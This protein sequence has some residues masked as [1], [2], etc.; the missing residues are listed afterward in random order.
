MILGLDVGT[1][2]TKAV[3]LEN[4]N[5]KWRHKIATEADPDRAVN[6]ILK[7]LTAETGLDVNDLDET[8]ITGWGQDKVSTPHGF[9]PI[10]KCLARG[11]LWSDPS[12]RS[13]LCIGAQQSVVLSLNE[14]GR[15]LGFWMN[16][17]C[18]S[19]AGMFLE[20]ICE[21]LRCRV[22]E[23]SDI[24]AT[25]DQ[26]LK[27]SSQCAVFAES[28][29]VSLVNDGE[30]VANIMK[31]ILTALSQNI[32]TLCK[33]ITHK[34]TFMVSGGLANNNT[35]MEL[36]RG[37]LQTELRLFFPEPDF[38]AAVGAAIGVNGRNS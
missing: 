38:I 11:A 6:K 20:V 33:K 26:K 10:L 22:E 23:S 27:M 15:V 3:L 21:A 5:M 9:E 18:A 34:E 36:L 12:C 37:N 31:G 14:S 28:E 2:F 13:L 8:L 24:A 19:G 7:A 29:V 25:S 32:A 16:D 17:K 30:S 4:K 35:L 1:G